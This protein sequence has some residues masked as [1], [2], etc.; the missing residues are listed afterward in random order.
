MY[1]AELADGCFQYDKDTKMKAN[2][3]QWLLLRLM[4]AH[5]FCLIFRN[6]LWCLHFFPAFLIFEVT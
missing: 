3:N 4:V 1:A 2:H 5:Y 6:E